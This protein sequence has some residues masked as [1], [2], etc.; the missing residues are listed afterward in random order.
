MLVSIKCDCRTKHH[1]RWECSKCR[2]IHN[3]ATLH[4]KRH[5][6]K[7]TRRY[8]ETYAKVCSWCGEPLEV[9]KAFAEFNPKEDLC[10]YSPYLT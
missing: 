1:S 4:V 8:R 10:P 3:Y 2:T 6:S 9:A 7:A 5:Y